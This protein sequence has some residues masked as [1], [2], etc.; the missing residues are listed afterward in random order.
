VT[1]RPSLPLRQA[2]ITR[3]TGLCLAAAPFGAGA[4][5]A[6]E[7]APGRPDPPLARPAAPMPAAPVAPVSFRGERAS[8]DLADIPNLFAR[9]SWLPPPPPPPP[10]P[11]AVAAKPP[12]PPRIPFDF[13]GVIGGRGMTRQVLLAKGD[14]LFIAKQSDVLEST[15]RIDNITDERI[16]MT[17]LPLKVRQFLSTTAGQ[18]ERTP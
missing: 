17:Y 7:P 16:E 4:Q 8:I 12:E 14:Q 9:H 2:A 6:P 5:P 15:Y 18:N 13:L 11:P 10:P 1:A 3:L